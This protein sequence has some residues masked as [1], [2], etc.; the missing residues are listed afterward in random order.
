MSARPQRQPGFTLLEVMLAV[1]ILGLVM[2]SVYGSWTAALSGWRRTSEVSDTFQR[3]RVVMEMLSELTRSAVFFG[4]NPELYQVTGTHDATKGDS[5]SFVT[6]SDALLPPGEMLLAGMRRVT[7]GLGRNKRDGISLML[8]NSAALGDT[9]DTQAATPSHE[10]SSAVSGFG[11]R[12][13]DPRDGEWKDVWEDALVAPMAMEFTVAFADPN[14]SKASP[15][16]VTRAVELPAA[17]GAMQLAGQ[18]MPQGSTNEVTKQ[19]VSTVDGGK[20]EKTGDGQ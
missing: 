3:Q 16:T 20:D 5:V 1:T 11:V 18:R 10:I 7:I 9:G 6:A 15:F 8:E 4:S 12:Y 17:I 13:R 2:V 19:D 14:N